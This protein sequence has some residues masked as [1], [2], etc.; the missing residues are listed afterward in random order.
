MRH[1]PRGAHRRGGS[2]R[3][4]AELPHISLEEPPSIFGRSTIDA[5]RSGVLYG[6]AGMI[7]SMIQRME[8]AARRWPR[9]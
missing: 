7:D 6:N 2:L 8:E 3:P 9:W 4:A 1:H 5:M